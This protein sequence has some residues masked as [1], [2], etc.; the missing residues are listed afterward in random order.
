MIVELILLILLCFVT[1]WG[2]AVNFH[3]HGENEIVFFWREEKEVREDGG[4][5][6]CLYASSALVEKVCDGQM[7]MILPVSFGEGLHVD[8]AVGICVGAELQVTVGQ[9]RI[10]LDGVL[11]IRE[12]DPKEK[13]ICLL[14]VKISGP[15]PFSV[16]EWRVGESLSVYVK[17]RDGV[18]RMLTATYCD[19][20]CTVSVPADA[21]QDTETTSVGS[22][23]PADPS[24][25]FVFESV[26]NEIFVTSED[27]EEETAA[28]PPHGAEGESIVY[29]GCQETPVQNG[30]Y[31]VRLLFSGEV[32]PLI[33]VEGGGVLYASVIRSGVVDVWEKNTYTYVSPPDGSEWL[34]YTFYGLLPDREYRFCIITR[35]GVLLVCYAGGKY[36]ETIR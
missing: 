35:D 6:F 28:S 21:P 23:E 4:R 12:D 24:E 11:R 22:D 31:A 1:V 20:A 3:S 13:E 30:Q 10:L 17:G 26:T 8:S 9:D 15:G 16:P 18:I 34:V 36:V 25:T 14:Q 33:R 27:R 7:A 5:V 32:Y 2:G 29:L 19:G